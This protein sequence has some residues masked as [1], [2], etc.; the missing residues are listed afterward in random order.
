MMSGLWSQQSQDEALKSRDNCQIDG[1][2]SVCRLPDTWPI[3]VRVD[4]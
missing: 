2:E 1:D 4:F 3:A